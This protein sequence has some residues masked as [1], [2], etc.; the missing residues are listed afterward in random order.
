M[1][2]IAALDLNLPL[3]VFQLRLDAY[4]HKLSGR[5]DPAMI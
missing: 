3:V 2:I 4:H 5:S 1:E